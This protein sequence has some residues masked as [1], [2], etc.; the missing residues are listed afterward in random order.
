MQNKSGHDWQ[1]ADLEDIKDLLKAGLSR[2]KIAIKFSELRG[3]TFTKGQIV[4][5][6][7]RYGLSGYLSVMARP[8]RPRLLVR[9]RQAPPPKREAR[10]IVP[11]PLTAVS[12]HDYATCKWINGDPREE[13]TV[14]GQ[15]AAIN[16]GG[17]PRS[18]C[19][20]HCSIAYIKPGERRPAAANL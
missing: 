18:Y 7:E 15:P 4:G 17:S 2:S 5:A 20:H 16:D 11:R 12:V 14:C 13:Y 3:R 8:A 6:I 19:P 10:V 9:S 1:Q